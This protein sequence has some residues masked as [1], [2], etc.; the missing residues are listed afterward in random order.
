MSIENRLAAK[1]RAKKA[2]RNAVW[3]K[4]GPVLVIAVAALLIFG[5]YF[6]HK[7]LT[8]INYSKGL[9]KD[10]KIK[11]YNA[12]SCLSDFPDLNSIDIKAEEVSA[13]AV[14]E[15]IEKQMKALIEAKK[16]ADADA[17]GKDADGKDADDKEEEK[18]D[19]EPVDYDALL[20]DAWVEEYASTYLGTYYDHTADGFRK[21]IENNLKGAARDKAESEIAKYLD[22]KVTVKTYPWKFTRNLRKLIPDA[23]ERQ[24]RAYYDAIGYS[25]DFD[26]Y[27]TTRYGSY[28]KYRKQVKENAN[29]QAKNVLIW[30]AVGDELGVTA[31]EADVKAWK[32]VDLGD[33][34]TDEAKDRYWK[35]E[36]EQYGVPYLMLDYRIDMA[37]KAL[38][39]KLLGTFE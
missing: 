27:V 34:A 20:T 6:L 12:K 31:T 32:L 39:D 11:G 18:K 7:D 37:H 8:E 23:E 14:G 15:E 5:I 35:S 26:E 33:N 1:E 38:Y 21:A 2:R 10:G 17:D 19:E 28:S 13:E 30:L 4:V 3:K 25:F 36:V 29:E 16:S 22:E 24:N 9:T